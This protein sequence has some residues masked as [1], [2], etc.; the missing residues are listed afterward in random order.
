VKSSW[1]IASSLL[2]LTSCT[3]NLPESQTIEP[4]ATPQNEQQSQAPENTL[5]LPES[6]NTLIS[7]TGIG[8]A[9]LGMTLGELKAKLGDS[10]QFDQDQPLMVDLNAIPVLKGTEIQYYILHWSSEPFTDSSPIEMLLTQNPKY[11]TTEGV[12]VG[13]L[14]GEAEAIYG[15][16]TLSYNLENESREYVNFVNFPAPNISFRV[17]SNA[18]NFAGI[19]EEDRESSYQE[20]GEFRD[21]A[22]INSAMVIQREM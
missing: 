15:E 16:A 10:V 20:T 1:L 7:E 11:R 21:D 9:Q 2:I 22:V 14:V 19:Y 3:S 5:T 17:N 6:E 4:S 12:G 8:E 13:T 18:E